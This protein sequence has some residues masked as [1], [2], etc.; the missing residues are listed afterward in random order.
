MTEPATDPYFFGAFADKWWSED[1]N[2]KN[3]ASFQGPRFAY[4]DKFV[5]SWTG[6]KVLD[7]GCAGGFTT[8]FLSARGALVSGLDPSPNLIAVARA[9]AEET[10]KTIDYQVGVGE[11]LPYADGAFD[12]VTCVDVLEHVTDPAQTVREI[13]RVLAPGG[14]FLYDTINRTPVSYFMMIVMPEY[15]MK[16]VPKGAHAYKD[17]IKPSEMRGYLS[18]AGLTQ[19]DKMRGLTI[20]G[21]RKDGSLM[22]W[23]GLDSTSTYMN[24]AKK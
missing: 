18:G 8:E 10:G 1:S 2:M 5:D 12:I 16:I 7:V 9:H 19:L 11:H 21:Q 4:F 20:L 17:F 23:Q 3:L 14:I 13:A 6:K 22:T 24:V 15:V